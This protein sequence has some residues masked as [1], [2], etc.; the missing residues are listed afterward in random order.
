MAERALLMKD[1]LILFFAEYKM[2]KKSKI[3]FLDDE[4]WEILNQMSIVLR[5]LYLVTKELSFEKHTTLSKVIPIM[6]RLNDIYSKKID[7]EN[8][9]G[10]ELRKTV[11]IKLK[12]KFEVCDTDQIYGIST[13][14]DPRFKNL[15]FQNMI[16]AATA[17]SLAK[18]DAIAVAQAHETTTSDETENEIETIETTETQND[19]DEFWGK[20]DAK[21]VN[22]SKRAKISNNKKDIVDLEMRQYLSLPKLERKE[23]PIIWWK[24]VGSKQ[25]PYLFEAAKKYLCMPAT[26]VPSERVF[27]NAGNILNKKRTR[28]GKKTADQLITLHTN[29]K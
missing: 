24:N 18:S 7:N 23:C 19:Y 5:P 26:S 6:T 21:V 17:E 10:K 4:D 9:I 3:E 11:L 8:A 16:K 15:G 1:A 25:F 27:S 12:E 20:F 13:I 2:D 22:P 14:F 28:L 29:L